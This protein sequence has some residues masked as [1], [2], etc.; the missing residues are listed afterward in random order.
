MKMYKDTGQASHSVSNHA[1]GQLS[2]WESCYFGLLHLFYMLEY[3][4]FAMS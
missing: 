1:G 4:V 2:G 3:E